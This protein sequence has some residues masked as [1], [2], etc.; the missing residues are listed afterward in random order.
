MSFWWASTSIQ[1]LCRRRSQ[2]PKCRGRFRCCWL[3]HRT[4]RPCSSCTTRYMSKQGWLTPVSMTDTGCFLEIRVVSIGSISCFLHL[5]SSTRICS[6]YTS[7]FYLRQ[8]YCFAL[9][10]IKRARNMLH[11]NFNID[12]LNNSSWYSRLNLEEWIRV[13][14]DFFIQLNLLPPYWLR[15]LTIRGGGMKFATKISPLLN[16]VKW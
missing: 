15:S 6:N 4:R 14:A 12:M 10:K 9:L 1:F 16:S 11:K 8:S 3:C 13:Y 5:F 2:R 7:P